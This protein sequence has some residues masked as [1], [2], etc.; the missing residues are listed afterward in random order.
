MKVAALLILALLVSFISG[1]LSGCATVPG[2]LTEGALMRGYD[3]TARLNVKQQA[4]AQWVFKPDRF[5]Y[6][7]DFKL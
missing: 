6:Y 1:L 3:A 2:R 7:G 4:Q 5:S